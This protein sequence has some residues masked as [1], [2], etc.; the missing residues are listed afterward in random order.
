MWYHVYHLPKPY[1][2]RHLKA[3]ITP[4]FLC[5]KGRGVWKQLCARPHCR[6]YE[7]RHVRGG[8]STSRLQVCRQRGWQDCHKCG[9]Q[10]EVS[11]RSPTSAASFSRAQAV[12]GT[13]LLLSWGLPKEHQQWSLSRQKANMPQ[14][15]LTHGG[16]SV[17]ALERYVVIL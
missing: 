1:D 16:V 2:Q 10:L 11:S 4:V 5:A 13:P 15:T 7:H 17:S 6:V 3:L 9:H 12:H 8:S 14:G